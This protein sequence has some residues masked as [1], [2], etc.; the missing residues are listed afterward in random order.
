MREVIEGLKGLWQR[1]KKEPLIVRTKVLV[2]FIPALILFAIT[3]MG[4][5]AESAGMKMVSWAWR[6]PRFGKNLAGKKPHCP[7]EV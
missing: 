6:D 3:C 7:K 1:L 5:F 2:C 4:E